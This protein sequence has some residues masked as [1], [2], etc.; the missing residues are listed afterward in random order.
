MEQGSATL[1]F[2]AHARQRMAN[3]GLPLDAGQLDRAQQALELL[4]AKGSCSAAVLL[5]R[6]VLVLS[7][8]QSLVVT[9]MEQSQMRQQVLTRIDSAL[10]A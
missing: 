4:R 5:D 2:S 1:R 8:P 3:R 6:L 7:V 10:L 9:V